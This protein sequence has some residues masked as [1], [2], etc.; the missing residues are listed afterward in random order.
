MRNEKTTLKIDDYLSHILAGI[1]KIKSYTQGCDMETF[2][3]NEMMVDAVL[4]NL[5]N[6]GEASNSI[7]SFYEDQ[8]DGDDLYSLRQAYSARN[9]LTHAYY[10]VNPVIV[11]DTIQNDIPQFE[12]VINGIIEKL[13]PALSRENELSDNQLEQEFH[14][15]FIRRLNDLQMCG[16]VAYEQARNE[17]LTATVRALVKD[18]NMN[19]FALVTIP[20]ASFPGPFAVPISDKDR[21]LLSIGNNATFQVIEGEKYCALITTPGLAPSTGSDSQPHDKGLC[22]SHSGA[23]SD[24]DPH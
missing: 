23:F 9:V 8:I 11:W 24:A 17:G 21:N 18:A 15:T 6:V 14:Q 10:K 5:E 2:C 20:E 16:T 12:I 13:H 1:I 3:S 22:K 4:K 19:A 7:S